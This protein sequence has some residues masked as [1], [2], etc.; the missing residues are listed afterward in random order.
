[1]GH[2]NKCAKI[3][4]ECENRDLRSWSGIDYPRNKLTYALGDGT[5]PSGRTHVVAFGA[6]YNHLDP[7]EDIQATT[8][9]MKNL[10]PMDIERLVVQFLLCNNV[11]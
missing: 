7:E 2:V 4:A 3:H 6:A 9:A 1:M 11:D 10:V 8:D 5:T